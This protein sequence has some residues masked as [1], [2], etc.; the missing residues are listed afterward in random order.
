M[1]NKSSR[2]GSFVRQSV[3]TLWKRAQNSPSVLN[4]IHTGSTNDSKM[5]FP[6]IYYYHVS[7]GSP[8]F[9]VNILDIPLS[10]KDILYW[11]KLHKSH[12]SFILNMFRHNIMFSH[13]PECVETVTLDFESDFLWTFWLENSQNENPNGMQPSL[14]CACVCPGRSANFNGFH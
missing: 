10:L 4:S 14:F 9:F 12:Y 7:L 11:K 2:R 8:F 6:T 5:F 3:V 13:N 1:Y